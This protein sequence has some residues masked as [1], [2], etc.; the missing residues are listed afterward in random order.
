MATKHHEFMTCPKCGNNDPENEM[1]ESDVS[2]IIQFY[3]TCDCGTE[4]I[5]KY[6]FTG[7]TIEVDGEETEEND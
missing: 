6:E 2:E 7:L 5:E 3:C 4:W 1:L